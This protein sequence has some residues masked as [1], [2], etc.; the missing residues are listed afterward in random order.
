MAMSEAAAPHTV[1]EAPKNELQA[2][3]H[4]DQALP[5]EGEAVNNNV[6]D[7]QIVAEL[8]CS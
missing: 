2:C 5:Q 3:P 8:P 4:L 6:G 7:Y 1:E